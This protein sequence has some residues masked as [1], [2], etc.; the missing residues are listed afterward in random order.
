MKKFM[1]YPLSLLF[2]LCFGSLL[3]LFHGVQW[4]ALNTFGY[5]AQKKSVDLL[6][7][8]ILRCLTLLGTRIKFEYEAPLPENGSVIF[9]ANHQ[10]TYDIPPLI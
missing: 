8:F 1:S 2:Y 10:S 5:T 3:V 7:F 4:I 9:V 6:N